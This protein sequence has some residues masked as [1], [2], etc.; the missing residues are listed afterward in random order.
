MTAMRDRNVPPGIQDP[1]R[2]TITNRVTGEIIKVIKYGAET[3]G[4][5]SE[6]EVTCLPG[7]GPPLHYHTSYRERF[8]AV[9][10]DLIVELDGQTIT[11]K[12]G[13]SAEIPIGKIHRFTTPAGKEARFRGS[14]IPAHIGFERS[15]HIMFGLANDGFAGEDGLP[16]SPVQKALLASMSDMRFVGSAGVVANALIGAMAW[17]GRWSGEEER[18]LKKYWD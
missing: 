16:R 7:G 9:E 3:N 1:S 17:Y 8:T 12:P 13:E 11:L 6:G 5:Y 4:E 2:R 10:G 18:L 15:L 14:A